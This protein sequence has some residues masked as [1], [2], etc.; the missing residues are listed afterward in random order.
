MTQWRQ[1]VSCDWSWHSHGSL[2]PRKF[3][4]KIKRSMKKPWQ[5]YDA[6]A[7]PY[8]SAPDSY[9]YKNINYSLHRRILSANIENF[10]RPLLNERRNFVKPILYRILVQFWRKLPIDNHHSIPKR[11][12]Q[13]RS[14]LVC[15]SGERLR[16]LAWIQTAIVLLHWTSLFALMCG[17]FLVELSNKKQISFCQPN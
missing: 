5:E 13:Q 1:L 14:I 12:C 17:L 10:I 15:L 8:S 2:I 9:S 16:F 6:V 11:R 7:C 4:L 3:D